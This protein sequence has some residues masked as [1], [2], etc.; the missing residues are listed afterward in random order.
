VIYSGLSQDSL[1]AGLSLDAAGNIFGASF[2]TIFELSPN[3]SGG[4]NPTVIH[5]FTAADGY[6][7]AAPVLDQFGNL[8][9]TTLVGG[10]NNK[11]TVFELSPGKNG[12][13]TETILY[14]FKGGGK[15]GEYPYAGLIHDAAGNIYGVAEGGE[16]VGKHRGKHSLGTV[17]ELAAPVGKGGQYNEKLLWKFNGTDGAFPSFP[18]L[19]LDSEGNLY[20]TIPQ[21]GASWAW[22][23]NPGYG[24]VFEVTGIVNPTGAILTSSPNPSTYGDAVTFAATVSDN[25]VTPPDG[26][27]VSFMKGKTVLGTGTLS[28]GSASF[29]TSTLRVGTTKVD[30]VYGGDSKFSGST[31]NMV[32]QVVEKSR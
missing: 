10:T 31:S 32:K 12:Q 29:T 23:L 3:G 4:W 11:G 1:A 27:T 13:W 20:G 24:D 18:S 26:E 16:Y 22:P 8:Y 2:L 28:G 5:T 7:D 9:G 6:L 17:F 25:G 19:I 14:S 21:G 15:D 30:A